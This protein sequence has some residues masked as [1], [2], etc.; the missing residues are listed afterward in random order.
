MD[1]TN[2]IEKAIARQKSYVG[3]AILTFFMYLLFYL[4]GLVL[5]VVYLSSA[6]KTKDVAGKAPDGVGC[7]WCL[8][9]L[10][11]ILPIAVFIVILPLASLLAHLVGV[12]CLT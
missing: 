9:I 1:A 4:P 6:E 10:F 3:A 11:C 7:L 8:L 2:D 5:N 12:T